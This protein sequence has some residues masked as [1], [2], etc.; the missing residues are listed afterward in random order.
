MSD[1]ISAEE[2]ADFICSSV[3]QDRGN[4]IVDIISSSAERWQR[5]KGFENTYV[6]DATILICAPMP[7]SVMKERL[8]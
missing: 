3:K 2:I 4:G 5:R 7:L 1:I 8:K 6:D